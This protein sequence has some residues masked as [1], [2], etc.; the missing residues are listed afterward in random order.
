MV[1]DINGILPTIC[2]G[3]KRYGGLSPYIAEID[4]EHRL[5]GL[6]DEMGKTHITDA[7]GLSRTRDRKGK[8]IKR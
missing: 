4:D 1:Y 7:Y 8:V 2:N 6:S 3:E 5:G